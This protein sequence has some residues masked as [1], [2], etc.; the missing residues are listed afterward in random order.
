MGG[1]AHGDARRSAHVRGVS[2][3]GRGAGR[4]GAAGGPGVVTPARRCSYPIL[5]EDTDATVPAR[6][7][8]S[9]TVV[10]AVVPAGSPSA[11]AHRSAYAATGSFFAGTATVS[12]GDSTAVAPAAGLRMLLRTMT[13]AVVTQVPAA[14][15]IR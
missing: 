1:R 12:S 5:P 14:M 8:L 9:G 4:D 7:L 3:G 11:P 6:E 2:D 13:R 15:A 10:F